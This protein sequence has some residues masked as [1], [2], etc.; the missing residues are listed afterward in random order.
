MDNILISGAASGIGAATARLFHQRGWKVGLL[1]VNAEALARLSAELGNAWFV[2]LDVT[3]RA[4]VNEALADFCGKHQGQLRL[5][6]NC[7]GVLRFGKFEEISLD[8]H[9]RILN[10]NV[11]GL[12]Q[13][14]Y[15]A[16]GYLKATANAQVINM[17]SASGLYG[18]PD[19]ASYSAS[20]FAVRG[21]TEALDL[22]WERHGIRVGDLMPPFVR[23][24]MVSSQTFEPPAL[25][26]LGVNLAAEDIAEAVWQQS[27]GAAVHRPISLQFSLLYWLGQITP[28]P[29]TRWMM[30]LINRP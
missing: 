4:A 14:T 27:Q 1:D 19:M 29:L 12:L 20:K 3:D 26:R 16:F 10:I 30:A 13:L 15:L 24:P 6:F 9:M 11:L 21:L 8:E 5:L 17:G 22:E 2:A 28:A 7:A 18:T 25:R 23:T